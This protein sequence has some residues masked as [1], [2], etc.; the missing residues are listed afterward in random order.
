MKITVLMPVWNCAATLPR[1]LNSVIAQ[2]ADEIVVIDDHSTDGSHEIACGYSGVRVHRHPEKSADHL[3]AL[4]PIVESLQTDYVLGI[5][6]D[7]YLYPGCVAALRRGI[8]HAQGERPGAVFAEY[9]HVSPPPESKRLCTIR[10]SP[11]MVYLPP[12]Q[13]RAYV[14]HKNIRGECGIASL[15]RHDLLVWLQREGYAA[16]G[17]RC[18][19]WGY[20]LAGLRAGAV[21]VPG[22][23]SAFTVGAREPSFSARGRANPEENK[24]IKRDGIAFLNRPAIAPYAQGINWHLL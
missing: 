15:I 12:E 17:H 6:A 8:L 24:R 21:Y 18:D 20:L 4:E 23:R 19:A 10:Y 5:G 7:D 2:G 3:L 14:A 16:A 1:A 13:Y 9:D 22:P 11:V